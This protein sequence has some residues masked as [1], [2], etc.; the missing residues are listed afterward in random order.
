MRRDSKGH[1]ALETLDEIKVP[2][3]D[4][5]ASKSQQCID[6][7]EFGLEDEEHPALELGGD[8]LDALDQS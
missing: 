4:V 3:A 6:M 1:L 5:D 2:E 8:A 7:V